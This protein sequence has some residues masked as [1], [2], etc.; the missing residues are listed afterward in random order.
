VLFARINFSSDGQNFIQEIAYDEETVEVE[1]LVVLCCTYVDNQSQQQ[2]RNYG[3]KGTLLRCTRTV[4]VVYYTL[5]KYDD[6]SDNYIFSYTR[7]A[8]KKKNFLNKII[9]YVY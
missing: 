6:K 2:S 3:R 1:A 4:Y 7:C 8:K 9:V 5:D